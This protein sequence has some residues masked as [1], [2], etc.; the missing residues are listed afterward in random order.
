M[1][2]KYCPVVHPCY[3]DFSPGQSHT[4]KRMMNAQVIAEKHIRWSL[5][6]RSASFWHDNWV[7]TGPLCR[8][9]ESFQECSVVDFV[10]EARWDLQRLNRVLP[11][12]WVE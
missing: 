4:W 11:G 7:G 6:S 12:G 1:H 2:L 3:S 10:V 9:V 8:Q 5:G